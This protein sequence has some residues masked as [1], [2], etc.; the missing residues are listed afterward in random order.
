M[1]Q[2]WTSGVVGRLFFNVSIGSLANKVLL[3]ALFNVSK[4]HPW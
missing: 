3:I 2:L 4:M 1:V